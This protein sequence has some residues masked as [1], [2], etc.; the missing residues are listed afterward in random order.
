MHSKL[1]ILF[2]LSFVFSQSY[3]ESASGRNFDSYSALSLSMASSSQV[4]ETSGFSI[5]SNPSNLSR[6]GDSG[7]I[8]SGSNFIDSNFER[9]GLIVKDSFGDF[10]AESDYVKNSKIYN[11]SGIGIRYNQIVFNYLNAGLGLT[12]APFKTYNFS[13]QEEV[14]GQ[15]SSND[16][17]IFSRDPLLGYHRFSSKGCQN[18]IGLGSSLGF[19]TNIDIEASFGFSFNTIM[20][21]NIIEKAQV[22]TSLAIGSIVMEDSNKLSSLPNYNIEYDL[23]ESSYF[24]IGSNLV[25]KRYLLALSY[26]SNSTISKNTDGRNILEE[27]SNLYNSN[28]LG[29]NILEHYNSIKLSNIDNPEKVSIG[30][31]ILD[32]NSSGYNFVVNYESNR[33]GSGSNLF[34]GNRISVGLEHYMSNGIPLR[35]S[36]GYKKSQFSPYISS[37]TSFNAGS[38]LIHKNLIFDYGLQYIHSRYN[39]PDLFLV[40]GEFRP[41]LDVVNDSKIILLSTLTYSF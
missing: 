1:I 36:V 4:V 9:R 28:E 33:Y 14:R 29:E 13:Y 20:P 40:E 17:Q 7:F 22:D 6:N 2:F 8:I 37:I 23:G 10:L 25:Y 32:K 3:Y 26:Q 11:Y 34:S 24:I 12:I 31:A 21:G 18:V 41:D 38:S 39:Y 16:G 15:L 5:L 30:F 27:I 35:F 19:E